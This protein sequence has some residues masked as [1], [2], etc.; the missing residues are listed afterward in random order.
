[1]PQQCRFARVWNLLRLSA[2]GKNDYGGGGDIISTA[3]E[4]EAEEVMTTIPWLMP[5]REL[6]FLLVGRVCAL[7]VF[8]LL[9]PTA[10]GEEDSP[11]SLQTH[12]LSLPPFVSVLFVLGAECLVRMRK[13]LECQIALTVPPPSS[14]LPGLISLWACPY[15][16]CS[17]TARCRL[18]SA[19]SCVS[20]LGTQGS[21]QDSSANLKEKDVP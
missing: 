13:G 15:K 1:M 8:L 20:E 7:S 11:P 6:F 2:L 10:K 17:K 12:L 5:K 21:G 18:F 14:S 4:D 9:P 19:C 3:G 16:F